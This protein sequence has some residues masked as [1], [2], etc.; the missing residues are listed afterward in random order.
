MKHTNPS[1][2][3]RTIEQL[4]LGHNGNLQPR[5]CTSNQIRTTQDTLFS[6][7]YPNAG[8]ACLNLFSESVP[9][10]VAV[11]E[12]VAC[13]AEYNGI[14]YLPVGSRKSIAQRELYLIDEGVHD[15]IAR[16]F[17]T[18]REAL[19]A[20]FDILVSPC[21][22]LDEQQDLR[23]LVIPNN[24][25]GLNDWQGWIRRSV[26][27]TFDLPA[28]RALYPF[29]MS[30]GGTQ[31]KGEF[32]L[33]DDPIADRSNVDIIISKRCLKPIPRSIFRQFPASGMFRGEVVVGINK[34]P[35][36][37]LISE[38]MILKL[39]DEHVCRPGCDS[40]SSPAL[41]DFVARTFPVRELCELQQ[42]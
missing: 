20:H 22:I 14:T 7:L 32:A 10:P 18:C 13:G 28:S 38:K 25:P 21:D 6:L 8:I 24:V 11:V 39:L 9:F 4:E 30:F 26:V 33:M 35:R 42:Q 1:S 27:S 34:S 36:E 40:T 16:R 19:M 12:Q 17:C 37:E 15:A 29:L 5:A 3:S 23:V 41:R 31:A 2:S